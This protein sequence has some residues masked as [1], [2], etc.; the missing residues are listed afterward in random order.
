MSTAPALPVSPEAEPRPR[1]TRRTQITSYGI[2]DVGRK[3]PVNEDQFAIA[4][5]RR[6]LRLLQSSIEQPEQLLG[7]PLGHL[8]MVADGIGGHRAG[9]Y[10][11]AMAVVG[12]EN[13]LLNTVGWLCRMQGEGVIAELREALQTADRWLAEAGGRKPELQGMGTT[14]TMVYATGGSFYVA[15][16]GDSRCYL[17]REGQLRRLTRD[18]TFVASLVSNGV[19][20]QEEA[21][22]H[23]MRNI[24]T[25]AVGGGSKGVNPDVE[26]HQAAPGDLLL[27]CTDGL[28]GVVSDEEIAGVLRR[29]MAP[30]D[31][32]RH[33]VDEA[34]Q[35]GGPDN[36]TVVAARFENAEQ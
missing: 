21:A 34:N 25:N 15:H 3:R 26:K 36:I 13:L 35:R 27:L 29:E 17:W 5:V 2:T 16:A 31:T 7:E 24:V 33:F 28:T 10:A 20:T 4:E 30:A 32:C 18:H 14:L 11:A 12:V 19:L 8:L 23:H 1:R 9:E 6:G 22:H